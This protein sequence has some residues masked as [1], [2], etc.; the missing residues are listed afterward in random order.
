[1]ARHSFGIEVNERIGQKHSLERADYCLL[2]ACHNLGCVCPSTLIFPLVLM[3][4]ARNQ[5]VIVIIRGCTVLERTL[6]ASPG[7]FLI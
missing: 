2:S 4:N 5:R 1:M 6:A 7:G 3:G